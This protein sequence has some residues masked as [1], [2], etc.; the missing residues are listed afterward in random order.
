MSYCRFSSDNG[1][2][3]DVY[4]YEHVYGG[5]M[6]HVARNRR[7]SDEPKPPSMYEAIDKSVDE[8]MAAYHGMQAWLERAQ[9]VPIG[10]PHDGE[11]YCE[12]TAEDAADRLEALRAAGYIVPQPA[13]DAL[14]EEAKP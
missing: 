7:V 8:M 13:I 9:I 11:D 3:S 6:I 14:R 4:C 10:L 12:H 2:E 1:H 5:F